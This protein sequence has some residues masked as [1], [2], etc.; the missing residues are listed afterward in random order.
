MDNP[1]RAVRPTPQLA[2]A[3]AVAAAG[4]IAA[5]TLLINADVVSRAL[6]DRPLRGV[7]ELVTLIMPVTV[8]LV[9]AW[10]SA[11]GG[12]I[13]AGLLTRV[14]GGA[15]ARWRAGLEFVFMLTGAGLAA[16]I[17]VVS[18]PG[19]LR[20]WGDDEFLG[21]AGDFTV[22][23]WPAKLGVVAGAMLL[24]VVCGQRCAEQVRRLRDAGGAAWI[25]LSLAVILALPAS[26][27]MID[28]HRAI[29]AWSILWMFILLYAGMPVA[30]ALMTS[31]TLGIAALKTDAVVALKTLGLAANGAVADYVFGAVPLFVLM[32]LVIGRADIGRDA[33]AAVHALLRWVIG[34]LGVATVLANALFAAMTGISI[35]SAAIFSKVAVPPLVE[36]GFTPR[37]A[38]GLV[39]GSS[40]LGM[41]IPP[42]LLLIIYGLVAEVSINALFV[43]AIV[44][45][46]MLTAM[47]A[48]AVIAVS[49]SRMP[50]AI[51][52]PLE[53]TPV[54]SLGAGAALA[55]LL[56]VA[57]LVAAVLGGIYGGLF[58]PT[59]AGAV[60]S[61]L[62]TV[63]AL[64][65]RRLSARALGAA[66][67]ACAETS[68]AILF[69]IVAASMFGMMLT[70]SGLPGDFAAW[71]AESELG[72][73]GYT[74]LY[75][76]VLI[77]LGM[78]ID[79]S[80]ILLIMVPIGL[81][82]VLSLG[83]D[84]VWFGI[85]TVIGVEI[86]LLTPPLGLSVFS[87]KSAL[88]DQSISLNDIF[89]GAAPFAVLMLV[90]TLVLILE[91]GLTRVLG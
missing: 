82:A 36:H 87:I 19:L 63:L 45:G 54:V 59:E 22:P 80:S 5:L 41:L 60:G 20:A 17:T 35:A 31:A 39:A 72:L 44:P 79:S 68:G 24:G 48:V 28:A 30:F 86:G 52:A 33:L 66:L 78:V 76:L 47:F 25:P 53:T 26:F 77:L 81:P 42:S 70:L 67:F 14:G 55:K 71:I 56:P 27:M 3:F 69:L 51:R 38:V 58:T 73:S 9:L 32:G 88:D 37:F 12:L 23:W 8:F 75:V 10:S 74:V 13:R 16:T 83:G 50:F 90:L 46:L 49:W 1:A 85:V 43:A 65:M 7:T 4:L 6:F 91:P 18:L 34:G 2:Y 15:D 40:V 11:R 64:A 57:V 21:V 61:L 89:I 29:G 84:P 62:A